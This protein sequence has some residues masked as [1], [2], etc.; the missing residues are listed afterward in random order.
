MRDMIFFGSSCL[1]TFDSTPRAQ[2]ICWMILAIL[3]HCQH[4]PSGGT[5]DLCPFQ[6][7][8]CHRVHSSTFFR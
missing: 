3:N 1:P 2:H 8:F 6:P 5:D 7:D 4:L